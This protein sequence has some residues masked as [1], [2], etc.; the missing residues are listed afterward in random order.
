MA[1]WSRLSNRFRYIVCRR[2]RGCCCRRCRRRRRR[3]CCCCCSCSC[4]FFQIFLIDFLAPR[5][6]TGIRFYHALCQSWWATPPGHRRHGLTMIGSASHLSTAESTELYAKSSWVHLSGHRRH[7][8][9]MPRQSAASEPFKYICRNSCLHHICRFLWY[10]YSFAARLE[11]RAHS[12]FYREFGLHGTRESLGDAFAV[13][14]KA[15]LPPKAY[16]AVHSK[17]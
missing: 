3:C 1:G 13:H 16:F 5:L 8:L 17:A 12:C 10:R 6:K 9:T 14:S 15:C 4:L 7:G 11:R 2:R